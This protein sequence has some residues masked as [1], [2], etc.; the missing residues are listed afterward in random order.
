MLVGRFREA[1]V[2]SSGDQC[3]Q[4][5]NLTA[6]FV[7]A[8]E[9][10]W[11]TQP[12][13]LERAW[14]RAMTKMWAERGEGLDPTPGDTEAPW[15]ASWQELQPSGKAHSLGGPQGG[16]AGRESPAWHPSLPVTSGWGRKQGGEPRRM[17]LEGCAPGKMMLSG[18]FPICKG[19]V[20]NTYPR[21]SLVV[22][23]L[24]MCLPMQGTWV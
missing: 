23:W 21:T 14:N 13:G 17:D 15:V 12:G 10:R 11:Y 5:G 8:A 3:P 4:P 9:H 7:R 20:R 24:R 6:V 22:Q 19:R 1:L 18:F 16:A 2:H